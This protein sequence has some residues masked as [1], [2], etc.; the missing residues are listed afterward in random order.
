MLTLI[1]GIPN[2][3]KTT[4]SERYDSV[5]H[6]DDCFHRDYCGIVSAV[7]GDVCIEGVFG[8]RKMRTDI[9]NACKSH[10]RKVCIWLDTPFDECME[11]ELSYR[12]RPL[13]VVGSH[14]K[15]FQ[16]PT[17]EEGWDEIII[18]RKD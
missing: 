3:G 2:A 14:H 6:L 12:N 11:R 4:Y 1:C 13:G 8:Q 5:I 17:Y 15:M 9:I 16:P 18:I 10:D 7:V